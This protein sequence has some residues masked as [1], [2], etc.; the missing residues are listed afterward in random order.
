MFFG[1][2]STHQLTFACN[3]IKTSF[4]ELSKNW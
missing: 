4:S 2:K 1:K 3:V